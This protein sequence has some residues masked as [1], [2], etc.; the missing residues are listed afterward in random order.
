MDA[1]FPFSLAERNNVAEDN[2]QEWV[3]YLFSAEALGVLVAA[4]IFGWL[5]DHA[6]NRKRP[7]LL[8][9]GILLISH[10]ILCVANNLAALI[11][12]RVLQ[13]VSAAAVWGIGL[14]LLADACPSESVG[15]ILGY[16]TAGY[17][18]GGLIAPFIGG[19]LYKHAGYN[20]VFGIGFGV[21]AVD[22]TLRLLVIEPK[23][24]E[25]EGHDE[26]VSVSSQILPLPITPESSLSTEKEGNSLFDVSFAAGQQD[27][28]RRSLSTSTEQTLRTDTSST[29]TDA[30]EISRKRRRPF[31]T[32]LRSRRMLF[33]FA[34]NAVNS[35]IISGLNVTLALFVQ[36]QFHWDSQGAGFIY[37]ALTSPT[38]L[39]MIY[40][41]CVDRF[42]PRWPATIGLL[43]GIVPFAC[44][45]FVEQDSIA[46]KV[47]Y[48]YRSVRNTNRNRCC[49]LH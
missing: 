42:G 2:V 45:R 33:N 15:K 28:P 7:L 46:H 20:A 1:V 47:C 19:V 49:S 24:T 44:L 18:I 40:G 16:A 32:L 38:L 10:T 11:I 36:D 12:G 5:S 37:I 14:A 34:L 43:I 29:L 3:E 26:T 41:R 22:A 13:G 4:P 39:Q 8:G 6:G 21:I 17:S 25:A 27:L 48:V 35:M 9:S 23:K 30:Q 31:V